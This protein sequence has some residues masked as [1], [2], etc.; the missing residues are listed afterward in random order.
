MNDSF[1]PDSGE[2]IPDHVLREMRRRRPEWEA[3][4]KAEDAIV[5]ALHDAMNRPGLGRRI[6]AMSV[7]AAAEARRSGDPA[8][9]RRES[10]MRSFQLFEYA[11]GVKA[12]TMHTPERYA[13][14]AEMLFM[15]GDADG[16]AILNTFSRLLHVPE[17]FN[18]HPKGPAGTLASRVL[19]GEPQPVGAHQRRWCARHHAWRM[20]PADGPWTWNWSGAFR[21]YGCRPW[22]G[23]DGS[24]YAFFRAEGM[25]GGPLP[26]VG[27]RTSAGQ[28]EAL[29]FHQESDARQW[30]AN[31]GSAATGPLRT[32]ADDGGPSTRTVYEEELLARL[33]KD[34]DEPALTG[35]IPDIAMF[36]SHLRAELYWAV[37]RWEPGQVREKFADAMLGAP[38][39]ALRETGWDARR[40]LAYLDR[41]QA[42]P[43][44]PAQ[45]HRAGLELRSAWEYAQK[46][47]DIVLTADSDLRQLVKRPDLAAKAGLAL[48]RR[49]EFDFGR[50]SIRGTTPEV[51]S[52]L[53]TPVIPDYIDLAE[54]PGLRG[55]D[56][57]PPPRAMSYREREDY[58][59]L[60][61]ERGDPQPSRRLPLMTTS[62]QREQRQLP[63]RRDAVQPPPPLPDPG[64]QIPSP[65]P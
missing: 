16:S 60:Q 27:I 59:R 34:P 3:E 10:M 52:W 61:E 36:T 18:H 64:G 29:V 31:R 53:G 62:E 12:G 37:T 58:R 39:W 47:P 65:R 28:D 9:I 50:I 30:L 19:F 42:T 56:P 32:T 63:G 2:L 15:D 38:G 45:A 48:T 24:R 11:I 51:D 7:D 22:R 4:Q 57:G 17:P 25:P 23:A 35:L 43:V 1:I 20:F 49:E 54:A 26:A 33:L 41:L 13:K 40:A 5:L 6:V 14:A 44:T 21:S 46:D 55:R 8:K